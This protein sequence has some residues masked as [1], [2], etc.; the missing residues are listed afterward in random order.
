MDTSYISIHHES[1]SINVH[2]VDL[3]K[4]DSINMYEIESIHKISIY[5]GKIW[6]KKI[7]M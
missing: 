7:L 2:D 5:G 6:H 4:R 3:V 1:Y